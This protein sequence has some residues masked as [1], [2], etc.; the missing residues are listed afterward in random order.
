LAWVVSDIVTRDLFAIV[1]R[2]LSA[3]ALLVHAT[4]ASTQT[5]SAGE[6]KMRLDRFEKEV[7]DYRNT[8]KIPG[9]S[10]VIVK[11]RTVLWA[12]G[13]G[14]ADSENRIPATPDTLYSIASLTK[15]F[16]ATLIMQLV[17]QGQL[18]LD[19]PISHYSSDFKDES[20]RIKHLLSHTASGTPGEGFRYDGANYDYVTAVIEKKT[21]KPFVNVVVETFFDPLGMTDSVPYHDVVNDADKW[22]ASLGQHH[23][24]RY[25]KNLTKL[26]QPYTYY[27][28][29]EIVHTTYP[30]QDSISA[31]AGLLSTVRDMA[32]YDIAIDRHVFINK[33]TQERAWTPFVSNG[34][35]RLPYGLGWFV[36][37]WHGLRLVWHYGHWG[38]GFSAMYLKI[39]EKN[40]SVVLLANSEALAD[41]GFED[42]TDNVFVCSFLGL[43]GY[44]YDC[45]GNAQAALVKWVEKRR[46][47]GRVAVP[48][49]PNI[50]ESYVGQ[51]QFEAL[52]NRIYT[53]T[54]DGDK[55]FFN[56]PEGPPGLELFAE[57]ESKFFL[58][59]R[60]YQLVFT[61]V[62]G[63]RPEL[64]I[65]NGDDTYHSKRIQ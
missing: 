27:G 60:T 51:Y 24:D 52:E 32:K 12:K 4:G 50:L 28:A 22:V 56:R 18:N 35:E 47:M 21:G 39:P 54:R 11:D 7:D 30:P 40:V 15:T 64:E 13:F 8:L 57:S 29:G 43:W 5:P 1:A 14:F 31:A 44:A 23:L 2:S 10:A 62:E 61:Q 38:T 53:I 26:A 59:I 49:H 17:E 65:V 63:Q 33:A 42:V 20:V 9:V 55:L 16:G 41:H 37:D 45:E 3:L 19:E 6:D 25:G 46:A 34:G 36:T 58:K 48:V